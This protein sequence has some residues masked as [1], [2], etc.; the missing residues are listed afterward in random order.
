M[1]IVP[2][3]GSNRIGLAAASVLLSA[4]LAAV[5]AGV[6]VGCTPETPAPSPSA[7]EEISPTPTE[8]SST[9][10]PT[11]STVVDPNIMFSITATATSPAGAVADVTQV[12]YKPVAGSEATA[13]IAQLDSE[14]DGW[15]SSYGSSPKFVKSTVTAVDRS[16]VGKHWTGDPAIVSMNGLPVFTGDFGSFQSPCASV[17]IKFGTAEG[18]TPV[19]KGSPDS[20]SGWATYYYGFGVTTEDPGATTPGPHDTKISNCVITLSSY[21]TTGSAIAASWASAAQTYPE[22]GCS[23][24]NPF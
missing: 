16:P 21:A 18:V 23:F 15:E 4:V 1:H 11:P 7:S 10:S 22:L 9:P 12:V 17:F 5:L 8:P 24:G 20:G 19:T 2:K 13:A 6:L 3:A 14:C